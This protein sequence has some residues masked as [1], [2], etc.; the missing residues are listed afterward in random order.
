MNIAPYAPAVHL[1]LI[2]HSQ[3]RKIV[4]ARSHQRLNQWVRNLTARGYRDV[5]PIGCSSACPCGGA[6]DRG[7]ITLP[8]S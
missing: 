4:K 1:V 2:S 8:S 3:G 7:D 6:L 5:Y